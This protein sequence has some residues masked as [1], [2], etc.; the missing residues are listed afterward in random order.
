MMTDENIERIK[1]IKSNLKVA[2]DYLKELGE[3]AE[4]SYDLWLSLNKETAEETEIAARKVDMLSKKLSYNKEIV[5]HTKNAYLEIKEIAG[6]YSS[7][8]IAAESLYLQAARKYTDILT[9]QNNVINSANAKEEK[10]VAEINKEIDKENLKN[11]GISMS[12]G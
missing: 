4:S 12:A 5:E 1:Q 9:L 10:R 7:D 6:E 2:S 8:A 11:V 3:S